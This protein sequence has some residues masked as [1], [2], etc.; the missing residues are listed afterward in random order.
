MDFCEDEVKI[1]A[2]LFLNIL[3]ICQRINYEMKQ[4]ETQ[5]LGNVIGFKKKD[6]SMRLMSTRKIQFNLK[7]KLF[8][9]LNFRY[10]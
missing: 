3:E 8:I 6:S 5:S 9:E 7:K 1:I 4:T 10:E 2:L